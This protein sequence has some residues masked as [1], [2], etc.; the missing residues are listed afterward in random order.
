[1]RWL[2]ETQAEERDG[3]KHIAA[4]ISE[5]LLQVCRRWRIQVI[6]ATAIP[7]ACR[8]TNSTACS[9]IASAAVI[10]TALRKIAALTI[11]PATIASAISKRWR[12]NPW[13]S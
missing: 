8:T 10:P 4:A 5:E 9:R 6:I 12:R 2:R 7:N 1:L 13:A 3:R 11:I